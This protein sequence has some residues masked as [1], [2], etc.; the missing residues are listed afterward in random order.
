M[1]YG[2]ATVE[3]T[4][5]AETEAR[6]LTLISR[7][8]RIEKE[9]VIVAKP[10]PKKVRSNKGVISDYIP[11]YRLLELKEL[12]YTQVKIAKLLGMTRQAVQARLSRHKEA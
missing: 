2:Q 9:N 5:W 12:G 1:W 6:K 10:A 11:T 7:Q 8:K 3:L 4:S